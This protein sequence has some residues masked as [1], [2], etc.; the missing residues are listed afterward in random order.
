MFL[1]KQ[2]LL[3]LVMKHYC[4]R[5]MG[6]GMDYWGH[7]R[8]VHVVRTLNAIF[9]CSIYYRYLTIFTKKCILCLDLL[10]YKK[11]LINVMPGDILP[12]NKA[13]I[14]FNGFSLFGNETLLCQDNGFWNG[15]VGTCRIG[16][17]QTFKWYLSIL[18]LTYIVK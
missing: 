18:C 11:F 9:E 1:A 15:S 10:S 7:A 12:F 17:F 3:C 16:I 14:V 5:M 4:V 6:P 8:K 2:A 13:L